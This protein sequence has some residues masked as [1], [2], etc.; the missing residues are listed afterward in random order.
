M[1]PIDLSAPAVHLLQ[2]GLQGFGSPVGVFLVPLSRHQTQQPF[3]RDWNLASRKRL[4]HQQRCG[5]KNEMRRSRTQG[6]FEALERRLCL[7]SISFTAHKIPASSPDWVGD[8]DGDGDLDFIVNAEAGIRLFENEGGFA[9]LSSRLITEWSVGQLDVLDMD[10]DG[11]LDLYGVLPNGRYVWFENQGDSSFNDTPHSTFANYTFADLD[12]D[13]DLDGIGVLGVEA[14]DHVW[15]ETTGQELGIGPLHHMD[16]HFRPFDGTI[17]DIEVPHSL[18]SADFDGDGDLDLLAIPPGIGDFVGWYENLDGNGTFGREN[19][20][21]R[22]GIGPKAEIADFDAD[23][24]LDFLLASGDFCCVKNVT[25]WYENDGSGAFQASAQLDT[26]DVVFALLTTDMDG[27]GALDVVTISA[28]S[29]EPAELHWSRQIAPGEFAPL[30]RLQKLSS[31]W[32]DDHQILAHDVDRDG[33]FDLV[34]ASGADFLWFESHASD[35]PLD[36][37]ING[38]GVVTFDDFLILASNFG[39]TEGTAAQG[40]LNGDRHIAFD[41]FLILAANVGQ[42]N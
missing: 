31:K 24:D 7:S 30:E 15:R 42:T 14:V 19:R 12:G 20:I 2:Q 34:V 28:N 5:Y 41:D 23:G 22:S 18:M 6:Q 13:G 40:D 4:G 10:L 9:E 37:D 8:F 11:D 35:P 32:S 1:K 17:V 21:G 26:Q 39:K 38:D 33:D 36:G 29:T 3:G 27:D 16:I 25:Q